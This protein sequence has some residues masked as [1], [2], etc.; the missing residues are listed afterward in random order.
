MSSIPKTRSIAIVVAAISFFAVAQSPAAAQQVIYGV[1][2]T[3]A[4]PAISGNDKFDLAGQPISI[5]LTGNE[6]MTPVQQGTHA[7]LYSGLQATATVQSGLVPTP[8]VINTKA[9]SILFYTGIPQFD[10]V[11]VGAKVPVLGLTLTIT[12]KIAMPK[13]TLTSQ[14]ISPFSAPAGLTTK[15]ANVS[16]SD[17]TDTTL[18]GLTGGINAKLSGAAA[19]AAM[20]DSVATTSATVV[21]HSDGAQAITQH[22]DGSK[23]VRSLHTAPV[24]VGSQT[25]SV[26]LRFYVSGLGDA[27]NVHVHVAGQEVPLLYVGKSA[28]FPGLDEVSVQ[29]PRTLA[30]AGDTEVVMTVNGRTTNPVHIHIQ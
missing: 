28:P 20:T 7:A 4:S 14:F 21:L 10:F 6:T 15:N 19:T 26:A 24:E 11:E 25:D 13:G 1:T 2:G 22:P 17:G 27:S 5:T 29:L 30:G 16:Y 9:T 18:L 12:A 8:I 23:S 3:F